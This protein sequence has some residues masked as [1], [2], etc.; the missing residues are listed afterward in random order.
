[1]V[2]GLICAERGVVVSNYVQQAKIILTSEFYR[3]FTRI[4][5]HLATP[6]N[7]T[8][9]SYFQFVHVCNR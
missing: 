3:S 1:M 5:S 6:I 9:L 7:L 8:N 4:S 2:I